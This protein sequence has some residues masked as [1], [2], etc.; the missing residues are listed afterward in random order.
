MTN[1]VKK[2][3]S[4]LRERMKAAGGDI[5][6]I[7]DNDPHISEYT[8]DHYKVREFFSGFTGS[9]GTLVVGL[10]RAWL[11]TDGRYFV[12]AERE[13]EGSG[14]ILMKSGTPGV[15]TPVGFIK[16]QAEK[17]A[18]VVLTDGSLLKASDGLSLNEDKNI[19]LHYDFDPAEDI[20][21]DRPERQSNGIF[22]L[23]IKF[24]GETAESKLKRVREKMKASGCDLHVIGSL[25]DI[26]WILNLRGNDIPCTPVFEAFLAIGEETVL[27]V[28]EAA[29]SE[30]ARN[31]LKT[32]K[33][34]TQN[35]DSIYNY[36]SRICADDCIQSLSCRQHEKNNALPAQYR[37]SI[38]VLIDR[39]G[40]NY[41]IISS[42]P[43][44]V[45]KY[46]K[47]P[48]ALM[49]AV[50]NETEIRHLRQVH[51]DDG[52]CVTRLMYMIKR[53]VSADRPWTEAD[54][55]EHIDA[56]RGEI[57]DHVSLSFPTISAFGANAA[58]MHYAFDR[59]NAAAVT[60]DAVL[61]SDPQKNGCH[62][63][64]NREDMNGA[65][66]LVDSGGQ[67][68]RGTTD[69]TRTF[70]VGEV[71]DEQKRAYTLALKGLLSLSEAVFLKGVSGYG[72]DI[73]ARQFL[74]QEGV[75]YRC[76]TGHGVGYMLNVHEGPNA[77]RYKY[78]P[79]VS[80]YCEL[81]P[82][83][84]T[85]CEPGVYE[86][87]RFGLRIE[88]ELLCGK[89]FENEYGEFLRFETLTLAPYDRDLMIAGMLTEHERK[90]IDEYHKKV[91][92]VL[93]P[94]LSGEEKDFLREYTAKLV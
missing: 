65:M 29:L 25:E 77:F 12:Q 74:W 54:V 60:A 78:V 32:A 92:E 49:R 67:Y 17:K 40:V 1:T 66:L 86:E 45:V 47:N 5:C 4:A 56:L 91:Y 51:E 42:L 8:G 52:L 9:A 50:K 41:K 48:S 57:P 79:G 14:I 85:T 87:G 82:G 84:V 90:L 21:T 59:D 27:F 68:L 69:V 75:D 83:M 61:R 22:S 18:A 70:A 71:P 55:A 20:W 64:D 93:S 7:T 15:P 63:T 30:K 28:N 2:H 33:V 89:A 11:F 23:D 72:L 80:D 39:Q 10:D 26:A 3:L 19:E 94:R 62:V 13:L 31:V 24:T 76:G 6:L 37:C 36:V 34:S 88:N 46:G 35:Y 58:M 16:L 44:G 81:E 43:D 38:H 73:L 53:K